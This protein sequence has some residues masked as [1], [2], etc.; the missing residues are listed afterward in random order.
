MTNATL[1]RYRDVT[2]EWRWRMI[3]DDGHPLADGTLTF[4]S[5]TA[6]NVHLERLRAV[7]PEMSIVDGGDGA[8]VIHS[9]ERIEVIDSHGQARSHVDVATVGSIDRVDE[10]DPTGLN[11]TPRDADVNQW[12]ADNWEQFPV[13]TADPGLFFCHIGRDSEWRWL[14]YLDGEVVAES[15]EG[16]ANRQAAEAAA[17]RTRNSIE[18]ADED[19]WGT[20]QN[21]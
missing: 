2:D 1:Q 8:V 21:A 13:H 12:I 14:L 19:T 18:S 16:Y 4:D 20:V 11:W 9:G 17:R 3:A 15:G 5:A 10:L 6:L 7:T